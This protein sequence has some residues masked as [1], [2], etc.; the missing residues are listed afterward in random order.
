MLAPTMQT[1]IHSDSLVLRQLHSTAASCLLYCSMTT[2]ALAPLAWCIVGIDERE[3]SQ[4]FPP[5][6][7][8]AIK[9]CDL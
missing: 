9:P 6:T 2:C 4:T 5:H 1:D 3:R 8:L 7:S